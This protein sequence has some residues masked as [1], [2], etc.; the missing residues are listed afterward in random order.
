VPETLII[1]VIKENHDPVYI[2]HPGTKRTYD[3]ISLC[4]WWPGIRKSIADYIK[5]ATRANDK[6]VITNL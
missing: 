3:L 4:Y 2:S 5:T 1:E 6:N